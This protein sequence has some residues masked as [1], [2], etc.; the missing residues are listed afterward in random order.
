MWSKLKHLQYSGHKPAKKWD[1]LVRTHKLQDSR[2]KEQHCIPEC[3]TVANQSI[4]NEYS[5]LIQGLRCIAGEHTIKL[6]PSVPAVVHPHRKVPVSLKDKIK[7]E[8][9]RMEQ[10]GVTI[11]Q[12]EPTDWSTVWSQWTNQTRSIFVLTP[13]I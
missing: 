3:S 1:I 2:P 12:T 7:D 8:L 10:T 9:D 13:G 4:F 5:D 6:D 11:R